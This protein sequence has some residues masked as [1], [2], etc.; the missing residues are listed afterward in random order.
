MDLSEED[1]QLIEDIY[2]AAY[3]TDR[4]WLSENQPKIKALISKIGADRFVVL[5]NACSAQ[6]NKD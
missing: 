3:Y 6:T 5:V 4:M 1:K 2:W